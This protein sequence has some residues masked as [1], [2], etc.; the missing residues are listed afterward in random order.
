MKKLIVVDGNSLLFRAYYATAYGGNESIMRTREGVPTNAIFAFSNMLLKLLSKMGEE[1]GIFVG[2]DADSHTFRKEEFSEYKANRKP[3]P[4][5][6]K[7]QF[8]ISREL[9]ENLGILSYE[10]HGVEADDICGSIAKEASKKGVTVEIYTSDRDYLQLIDSHIAVNL[11]KSGLSNM[12]RVTLE[13]MKELFGYS[14]LQIIDYKGLRG[15]ASDNLPGI[16]GIGEKTAIKLLEQYE[17]LENILENAS[18]IKGKLGENLRTYAEQGRTCYHLATIK[19]DLALPFHLEDLLYKGYDFVRMSDF[20]KKYE[21]NQLLSRLPSKLSQKEEKE[22]ET[23]VVSSFEGLKVP[24]SIGLSLDIDFSL[25]HEAE[26]YGIALSFGEKVYYEK[27]EDLKKDAVLQ[28]ILENP[29]IKKDVYDGKASTYALKRLGIT[30]KGV[31][32]DLLLMAYLLDSAL[33]SEEEAVYRYFGVDLGEQTN[34]LLSFEDPKRAGKMAYHAK[35]LSEKALT[36]LKAID[37]YSLY[38]DI[39]MSLSLILAEMEY[40]GFPL[41]REELLAIGKSFEE[42]RAEAEKTVFDIAGHSFNVNSPRQVSEILYKERHLPDRHRG[43]TGVDALK[44]LALLD[45]IVPAILEYR[46]YAKLMSTYIDGFLPH[47]GNDGKIHTYFNQAQTSTG[48]LSSSNPNLQNISARDEEGRQIRKAFYYDDPSISIVSMDY[49]QIELR[50]LAGLSGS[51]AYIEVFN[52]GRDVHTETAKLIFH[53][54]EVTPAMRR[55]AKAVNFA[56]IYGS[57]IYG[58]ADQIEG[59]PKEAQEIIGNFYKAY[60]EV[61]VYLQK[62]VSDVQS[63]G[64]VT[65][66]FGRRRYLRDI[67]DPSYVKREAARRAA[68]N[69]P[70]QGSAADLIKK[71]M[72]LIDAFL[73]EGHYKTEMVLQIH[74][75]LLFKVPKDEEAIV[76]PRLKELMEH[77][78][79]LPVKLAV[80]VN[81]GHTWYEAKD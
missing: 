63:Q 68:L 19:T 6:L 64:F 53:T 39:E 1:D 4:E 37:A 79:S 72:V 34:G 74:D 47:I 49:H 22:V 21:L 11:L 36:S 48:R 18:L 14:P 50:I 62:I 58:L 71:A 45:P 13:N 54:E 9:C 51:K 41:H 23:E 35:H 43:A 76:V 20:S 16:P 77:A 28:G 29:D 12:E 40:E 17:S 46:K 7:K 57:S 80:E 3:C 73:K 26:V 60:P 33:P 5:D 66:M 61:G 44:E 27:A 2:F 38:R 67:N 75:E 15:D 78:V 65:T 30:L 56:I 42:K 55:K 25:Y 8:P 69:A 81:I 10:E 59:S 24:P 32:N 70:I 52:E 31:E